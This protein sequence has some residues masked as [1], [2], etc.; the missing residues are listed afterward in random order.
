MEGRTLTILVVTN[1]YP[2]RPGGIQQFVQNM[3]ERLP[4]D[5]TVVYASSWHGDPARCREFDATQPHRV[6]R[7]KTSML[8]PTPDRTKRAVAIARE[9]GAEAVW[10]GAAAPLGLMAPALRKAGVRRL[11]ATTHGHESGW[12][13]LPGARDL[14]RRIADE[15]DCVTYLNEYHRSR[16]AKALRP[17][18]AARMVQ[19]T[20][21]VDVEMFH[22]HPEGA[23]Q[24]RAKLGLAGRPVVAC[25]S[26]LVPRKGQDT[27]IR[28]LPLIRRS[29]PDAALLI[30]SGGPYSDALKKL[31]AAEG[32]AEHVVFTGSVPW[33][34]LPTLFAVG[35]VFAMPCRTRRFGLDVEGLGIVYLEASA[36]GLPVIAGDSGGAPEAVLEGETGYVVPGDSVEQCAARCVELLSDPVKAKAMGE[37]G[38]AWVEEKWQWD[39]I[40]QIL[41]R[42][43]DPA[44]TVNP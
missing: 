14:L 40:A 20:P 23:A 30:G 44:V 28:A 13:K 24:M 18:A 39:S 25:V 19:L 7:E 35:D 11:V 8:L 43:L 33:E 42:L 12:A 1:D 36:A 22:P 2:P 5:R 16:I 27:L 26:R 17:A 31:A 21:G 9:I 37:R 4:A 34:Q 38:R 32:V 15:V 6:I 10:F 3:V 29:V 41:R